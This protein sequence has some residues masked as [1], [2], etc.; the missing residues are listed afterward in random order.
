MPIIDDNNDGIDD[1]MYASQITT[2][3]HLH[4]YVVNYLFQE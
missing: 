4:E 3:E 1:E 2:F